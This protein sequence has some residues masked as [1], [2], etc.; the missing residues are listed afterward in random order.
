VEVLSKE[1]VTRDTRKKFAEYEQAGV[2]EYW[3]ADPREHKRSLT[4]YHRT[5]DGTYQ[6]IPVDAE[7]RCASVVLPGL[8]LRPA[9][10]QEATL[11][12]IDDVLLEVCGEDYVRDMSERMINRGSDDFA[13]HMIEHILDR[14]GE[15]YAQRMID[16]L[17]DQG[18][19][20]Y[21]QRLI[22]RMLYRGGQP[23]AR[24]LLE[25]LLDEDSEDYAQYMI[26]LLRQR[27]LLPEN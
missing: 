13:E 24:H 4:M 11:P 7:G 9:W 26:E 16:H 19:E 18:G 15:V 2:R 21:A 14:G 25:H 22:N 1:S 20:A 23:Y 3:I 12:D 8:W 5:P 6:S 17:L 27:G 10:L